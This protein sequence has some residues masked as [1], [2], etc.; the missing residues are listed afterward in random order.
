LHKILNSKN[1]Y[2]PSRLRKCWARVFWA[3][4]FFMYI[5]N[6]NLALE[7]TKKERFAF[8]GIYALSCGFLGN[9]QGY[10]DVLIFLH[11]LFIFLIKKVADMCLTRASE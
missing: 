4:P 11:R 8:E 5:K 3:F 10:E 2:L 7:E 9:Y 1:T 6:T